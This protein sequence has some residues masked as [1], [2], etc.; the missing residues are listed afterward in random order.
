MQSSHAAS[1]VDVVFEEVHLIAEAGLVPLL[2]VGRADRVLPGLVGEHVTIVGP[3]NSA[4]ATPNAPVFS[5][6]FRILPRNNLSGCSQDR[7]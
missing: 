7:T 1:V 2:A 3:A 5:N 4:G 6:E